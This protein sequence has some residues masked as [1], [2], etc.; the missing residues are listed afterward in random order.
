MRIA[1]QGTP[2][3]YHEI[4]A[5]EFFG[6]DIGLV[7]CHDFETTFEALKNNQAD[8]AVIAI[9][10]SVFGSINPVY[11]LIEKYRFPIV[12]EVKVR[13][14]HQLIGLPGADINKITHVY[15]QPVALAQCSYFLDKYPK[16]EKIEYFDTAASVKHIVEQGDIHHA[17]IASRKSAE[18]YKGEILAENIENHDQNYTRFLVYDPKHDLQKSPITGADKA[19]LI[20]T[21]DHAPG[22]LFCALR[23]FTSRD[24]NLVNIQSR[25]I[26]GTAWRYK[27][28]FIV[29]SAGDLLRGAI[30]EILDLGYD[31]K[32]LGEYKRAK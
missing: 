24:M 9:E 1:I 14:S 23:A 17:A 25:P 2:G 10:N 19:S 29:E 16:I 12:G 13:I 7:Y 11:D 31:V 26:Q 21:T 4:A 3:A 27:F 18:F 6:P 22:A 5:R 8:Q 28:Y 20:V 32:L 15:S 30:D